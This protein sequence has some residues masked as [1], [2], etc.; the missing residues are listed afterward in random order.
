MEQKTEQIIQRLKD[1]IQQVDWEFNDL[2][3]GTVF[4]VGDG[5]V[6][7]RGLRDVLSGELV[8]F[9]DDT[10]GMALNL[11]ENQVGVIVLGSDVNIKEDDPVYRTNHIVQT[12]VGDQLAG[13]VVDAL[14]SPIDEMG[15]IDAADQYPSERR[16]PTVMM[17]RSVDQPYLQE[18]RLLTL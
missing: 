18:S 7:V 12:D 13:R 6:F 4:S 2:E 17:R 5:I 14:G 10:L 9:A 3:T 8:R 16:A 15:E 11:E 1:R